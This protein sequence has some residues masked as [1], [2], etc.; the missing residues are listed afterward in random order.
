MSEPLITVSHLL[1]LRIYMTWNRQNE[2]HHYYTSVC[3]ISDTFSFWFTSVKVIYQTSY[4]PQLQLFQWW[5]LGKMAP[6]H[7]RLPHSHQK[8]Q[9]AEWCCCSLHMFSWGGTQGAACACAF[10]SSRPPLPKA[11]TVQRLPLVVYASSLTFMWLPHGIT[12]LP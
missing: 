5:W 10:T 7:S 3:F 2:E 11:D 12:A 6:T 8:C 9:G 4:S 1:F